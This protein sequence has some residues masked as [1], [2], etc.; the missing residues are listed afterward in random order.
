VSPFPDWKAK[1]LISETNAANFS[2]NVGPN[3]VLVDGDVSR[4]GQA[5]RTLL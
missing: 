3:C 5:T 2:K 1:E 4:G